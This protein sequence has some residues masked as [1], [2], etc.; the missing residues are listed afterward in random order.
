[1]H[2][3]R[4]A[5]LRPPFGGFT[6]SH[7]IAL[8]LSPED[9]LY[10][11][12][13]QLAAI[14]RL[15]IQ[16][17]LIAQGG[18]PGSG[19]LQFSDPTDLSIFSGLDLFVADRGND[20][21]ARLNRRLV[22]LADYRSSDDTPADLSFEKPLSVLQNARGDLFVAD[23]GNDRVLKISADGQPL[24]SFGGYSE[25]RGSL[26]QPRRLEP[27]PA[28]GLWV[29]DGRGRAVH[30][31]EF[32]GYLEELHSG[33]TGSTHGLA[34]SPEAVWVCSD[35]ILWIWDRTDRTTQTFSSVDIGLSDS[36][37][38]VDL[39]WRGESLWLLDSSGA[40]H[41]FLIRAER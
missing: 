29:L 11:L 13:A 39:A 30:F 31:D 2:L 9:N 12:D 10:L 41:S 17:D 21:V 16:G 33:L 7:P 20:R 3:E 37:A 19:D 24:F 40:I 35:S 1:M 27:D 15:S 22:F 5:V 14:A 6:P 32:G 34:V 4:Q 28:A 8:T 18:G 25:E 36:V 26:F 38:M 23:G